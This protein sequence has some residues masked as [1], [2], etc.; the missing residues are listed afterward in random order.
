MKSSRVGKKSLTKSIKYVLNEHRS[1][2]QPTL[3]PHGRHSILVAWN[4]QTP[5]PMAKSTKDGK[6]TIQNIKFDTPL[7][8]ALNSYI[9]NV[10]NK[11]HSEVGDGTTTAAILTNELYHGIEKGLKRW[12]KLSPKGLSILLT[13]IQLELSKLIEDVKMPRVHTKFGYT[14]EERKAVLTKI[15]T[16]AANNDP[17]IGEQIADAFMDTDSLKPQVVLHTSYKDEVMRTKRTSFNQL[18]TAIDDLMYK[19]NNGTK[20]T[21]D[22]PYVL[23][24]DGA[25]TDND[26]KELS[27]VRNLC[28]MENK[29][30][31]VLAGDFHGSV[32][33]QAMVDWCTEQ[34]TKH[35]VG[36]ED[37]MAFKISKTGLNM[38][39]IFD[40]YSALLGA[41]CLTTLNGPLKLPDGNAEIRPL[42][43]STEQFIAVRGDIEFVKP[44][45]SEERMAERLEYLN[46]LL[47]QEEV[48]DKIYSPAVIAK[49]EERIAMMEKSAIVIHVGGVSARDREYNFAVMDDAVKACSAA[50]REGFL[51]GGGGI[52]NW[53]IDKNR[54][55]IIFNIIESI[56]KKGMSLGY[57]L[58]DKTLRGY[59]DELLKKIIAASKVSFTTV[60]KNTNIKPRDIKRII[61]RMFND[62]HSY[63]VY[64]T[65][66][67]TWEYIDLYSKSDNISISERLDIEQVNVIVPGNTESTI[68]KSAFNVV[69]YLLSAE[70][71]ILPYIGDARVH[72]VK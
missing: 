24:V 30:L 17:I 43:G 41:T 57:K 11:Q 56:R 15:A 6:D 14:P 27:K 36:H 60:L 70:N 1:A 52:I 58:D 64:N 34:T 29:P 7:N 61:K 20:T 19:T 44:C 59:I 46:S 33:N 3:G 13:E 26:F 65:L 32:I 8:E 5:I 10:Y 54:E 23:I 45:G 68:I 49:L 40:D 22:N 51:L 72:T 37:F 12:K 28:K 35:F 62:H 16:I 47:K 4:K 48:E 71:I 53:V 67:D 55:T 21:F 42:L 31:V 9:W 50:V 18:A 39:N 38:S 25:L 66:T 2:A 63:E 69:S